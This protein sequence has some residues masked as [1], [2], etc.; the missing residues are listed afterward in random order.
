VISTGAVAGGTPTFN[1]A[2]Y[3]GAFLWAEGDLSVVRTGSYA[4]T[5]GTGTGAATPGHTIAASVND[6]WVLIKA[7]G[8]PPGA[9]NG[10]SWE[11]LPV[12]TF[13]TN[14]DAVLP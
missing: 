7:V 1:A 5:T 9:C 14:R 8:S 2:V 10:P 13:P 3:N 6:R 4:G 12:A 11:G